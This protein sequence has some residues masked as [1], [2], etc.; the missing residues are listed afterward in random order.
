MALKLQDPL[1]GLDRRSSSPYC[2][3]IG[4]LNTSSQAF[5]EAGGKKRCN[6]F[7]SDKLQ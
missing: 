4:L 6:S 2:S 3:I 5:S 1:L 7:I